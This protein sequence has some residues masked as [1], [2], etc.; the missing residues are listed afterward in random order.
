M[1]NTTNPSTLYPGTSW[2]QTCQGRA[3]WGYGSIQA[4]TNTT[5]G[6]ITAGSWSPL[7]NERGGERYH[8]LSTTEM[9]QHTHAFFCG[10]NEGTSSGT[11]CFRYAQ[12]W[13]IT[14]RG[15]KTEMLGV[16]PIIQYSG[17]GGQH[18]N[19]PPFEAFAIWR[20]TA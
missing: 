3:L 18:N 1:Y 10:Y 12:T 4:N 7:I 19:V 2:T 15:Y 14:A 13:G 5:H 6:S 20:R 11:D 17:G 16:N 9:P 8:T